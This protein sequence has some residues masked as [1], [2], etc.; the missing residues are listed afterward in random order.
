MYKASIE[1]SVEKMSQGGEN[2]IFLMGNKV[3]HGIKL[4]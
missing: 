4:E 2:V 3:I 1:F